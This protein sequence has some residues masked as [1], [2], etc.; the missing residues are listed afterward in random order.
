MAL[1]RRGKTGEEKV[2]LAVQHLPCGHR[3][4]S[5]RSAPLAAVASI[6]RAAVADAQ[7]P[8]AVMDS[9]RRRYRRRSIWLAAAGTVTLAVLIAVVPVGDAV[10]G[11]GGRPVLSRPSD[12]PL[13]PGGGRLLLDRHGVLEWLY[14]DG[15]TRRLASG[16]AGAA[17]AGRK[18]LAWKHSNPPGAS[19]FLPHGCFDPDC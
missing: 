16:F 2:V 1:C 19:R 3:K 9:V 18:L 10:A 13:F 6:M 11:G 17:L 8:A 5:M 4:R 12:D 7:P 15:R 14:P